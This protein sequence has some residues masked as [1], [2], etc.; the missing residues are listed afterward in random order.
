VI[1]AIEARNAP[2]TGEARKA[3]LAAI[4]AE[5]ADS[6]ALAE[7]GATETLR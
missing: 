2:L 6:D 5:L 4:R 3:R 1:G 7:P